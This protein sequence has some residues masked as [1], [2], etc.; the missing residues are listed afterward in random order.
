MYGSRGTSCTFTFVRAEGRLA[1]A[2]ALNWPVVS[3]S[4]LLDDQTWMLGGG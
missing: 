3:S 4:G 2:G 1:P